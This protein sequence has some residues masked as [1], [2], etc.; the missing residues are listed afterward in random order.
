VSE[1][2]ALRGVA[3]S[4]G[5]ALGPAWVMARSRPAGVR[6]VARAS[7][8]AELTRF[9]AAIDLARAELEEAIAAAGSVPSAPLRDI[10]EAHRQLTCDPTLRARVERLIGDELLDAESAL[11]QV[12]GGFARTLESSDGAYL[13]ELA[14]DIEQVTGYVVDALAGHKAVAE[15]PPGVVLV[16]RDLPP[17]EAL[18]MRERGVVGLV[19]TR[20]S[21]TSHTALLARALGIPAV[22]GVRDALTAIETGT[23]LAVDGFA[24]VCLVRPSEEQQLLARARAT[25][26]DTFLRALADRAHEPLR[27]ADGHA[28]DLRANI[29]LPDEGS[30]LAERGA[31]GV[32][33]FRTEYLF[34]AGPSL[35]SEDEQARSYAQLLR[36]VAPHPVTFRTFDLGAD[37]LR[38]GFPRGG[39]EG[40]P[41]PNPALAPRGLRFALEASELLRAQ[42]RATLRAN[43]EVGGSRAELLFPM[44]VSRRDLLDALAIYT[45]ERD[46][47]AREGL[48]LPALP[49]GAMIEVPAAV[50]MVDV[51]LP[52]V[53]FVAIGTNDLL[54][55]SLAVDRADPAS[56]RWARAF[57]PALLRSIYH[58][59]AQ[60]ERAGKPV[61]VCGDAAADP[62]ALPILL[63]LGAR[64]LSVPPPA[65]PLAAATIRR[66]SM[67]GLENLAQDA[68]RMGDAAEVEQRVVAQLGSVLSD[69]WVEQGYVPSV[70]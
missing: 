21:A 24:G 49:L 12:M 67:E 5:I 15:P 33:L 32:G 11:H 26:F 27:T 8:S 19:A 23:P 36:D 51:L 68:I 54:Q 52:H 20:G 25:R 64:Q 35:P 29:E 18:R 40:A 39:R 48:T 16:V 34:L 10:L 14:H 1:G 38:E 42:L 41:S 17:R 44:V 45:E 22:V 60:A 53:D 9:E 66:L 70:T 57:E 43:A 62:I 28:V 63:G 2:F 65:L 59:I 7:V 46:A 30:A 6:R 61:R 56:A 13:R 3:V 69:L 58:V 55:Y 31:A 47:L 37:E 50:L 4:A